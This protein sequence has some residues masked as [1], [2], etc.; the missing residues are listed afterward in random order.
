M[1]AAALHVVLQTPVTRRRLKHELS[2]FDVDDYK[3]GVASK[4]KVKEI[5]NIDLIL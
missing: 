3:L 1:T 2:L 5:E 4:F